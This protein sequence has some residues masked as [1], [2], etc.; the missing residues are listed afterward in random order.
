MC[1]TGYSSRY[2]RWAFIAVSGDAKNPFEV[3]RSYVWPSTKER[4]LR[5]LQKCPK[6]NRAGKAYLLTSYSCLCPSSKSLRHYLGFWG[7][8][9]TSGYSPVPYS[10]PATRL[11]QVCQAMTLQLCCLP[12]DCPYSVGSITTM[13]QSHGVD[14]GN[15]LSDKIILHYSAAYIVILRKVVSSHTWNR[16][17]A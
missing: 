3:M 13:G 12:L 4:T 10:C 9:E 5:C 1:V 16:Y 2:R 7:R 11:S 8:V 14:P 15:V 6:P 17:P